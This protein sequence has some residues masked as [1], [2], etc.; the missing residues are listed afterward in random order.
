MKKDLLVLFLVAEVTID[1]FIDGSEDL[2]VK[3]LAVLPAVVS[4][5]KLFL[6]VMFL[7][8]FS[9]AKQFELCFCN[10]ISFTCK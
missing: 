9:I 10:F 3:L 6:S 7:Y 2:Q 1:V 5:I 8:V 4:F